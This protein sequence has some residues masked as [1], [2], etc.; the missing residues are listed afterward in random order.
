MSDSSTMAIATIEQ[1]VRLADHRQPAADT[2]ADCSA[3]RR[4]PC[5]AG[6]RRDR[7]RVA[8]TNQ[9]DA[10]SAAQTTLKH[11]RQHGNQ[12]RHAMQLPTA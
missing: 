3:A 5:G 2:T 1:S 11:D 9:R 12:L 4:L 8:D 10:L 7:Q 6:R